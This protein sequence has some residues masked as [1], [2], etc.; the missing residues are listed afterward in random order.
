MAS[1]AGRAYIYAPTKDQMSA[2]INIAID[3]YSSCG[4]STVA[5][6][7]ARQ[8]N[9]VY[10]DTGA[11]YRAVSL[12]ALQNGYIKNEELNKEG[13][14]GHLDGIYISF[15]YNS[16][17]GKNETYINGKNVE[18]EIRTMQVSRWVSPIAEIA[19]VRNKL[20]RQQQR[21]AEFKG[22]VMDGRDIGT[23]V[24]PDA[25]LKIFM[26]AEPAVR[27]K[28]RFEEL[29]ASGATTSFEEV[30]HNLNERDHIDTHRAVDPLRQAKDAI[31]LD[32]TNLTMDEQFQFILRHA[33]RLTERKAEV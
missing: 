10:I 19:E 12:F 13:L 23:V 21:M 27:A 15:R 1:I 31:V 6:A 26:T 5:K 7:L 20:V 28:R 9:Y 4:K 3:G 32:N 33:L 11:M 22:M 17:T 18:R 2:K 24:L 16:D 8:L 29:K 30:M 14:L 25:E